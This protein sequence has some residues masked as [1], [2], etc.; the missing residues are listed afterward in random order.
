MK[1]EQLLNNTKIGIFTVTVILFFVGIYF[2][3]LPTVI[4]SLLEML[5]MLE[6]VRAIFDYVVEHEHRVKVR[7]IVDSAIVFSVHEA[8]A[9]WIIIKKIGDTN[10]S[11]D[12]FY[13]GV[14]ILIISLIAMGVLIHYRT[15]VIQSS[16][17]YLEKTKESNESNESN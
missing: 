6:I 17:D 5:I 7:Y 1:L 14:G 11:V 4:L 3:D 15:K 9:G 10:I 16:P 2:Y 12:N 13:L 8:Y